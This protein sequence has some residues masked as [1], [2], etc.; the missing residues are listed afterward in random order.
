MTSRVAL[1]TGA[2]RGIGAAIAEELAVARLLASCI[3]YRADEAGALAA[4]ARIENAG[5]RRRAAALRRAPT[6]TP[7]PRRSRL[8]AKGRRSSTSSS[9]MRASPDAAFPVDDEARL[10]GRDAHHARRLLQRHAAA[11]HAAGAPSLGAHHQ[12]RVAVGPGR[13][14]R[15]GELLGGQ[16]RAS[17]A[18]RARSPRSSPSA[19]SRST[20]SRPGL[21]DTEMLKDLPRDGADEADPHAAASAR[22]PRS[23]SWSAFLAS[24]DAGYITGQVI[25]INGGLA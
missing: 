4:K 7:P 18:R 21:I 14:P 6:P 3:N 10:G 12:H 5:G 17:S 22:P 24:D 19:T 11:D 25:G 23:P 20:P 13:Q 1:V 15:A 8:G 16:G 2:S 9:T